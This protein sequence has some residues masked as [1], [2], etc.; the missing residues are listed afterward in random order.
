MKK[1]QSSEEFME[2]LRNTAV[3]SDEGYPSEALLAEMLKIVGVSD[4]TRPDYNLCYYRFTDESG[5]KAGIDAFSYSPDDSARVSEGDSDSPGQ[6]HLIYFISSTSGTPGPVTTESINAAVGEL[7]NL[8]ARC[9]L[10]SGLPNDIKVAGSD[11]LLDLADILREGHTDINSV[12]LEVFTDLEVDSSATY[13]SE[14]TLG[15]IPV[16]VAI[17]TPDRLLESWSNQQEGKSDNIVLTLSE[18]ST[19]PVLAVGSD[20]KPIYIT[21]LR[22]DQLAEFYSEYQLQ[23]VN[24]NIRAFLEFKGKTNK[25]IRDTINLRPEDFMSYNNGLTIVASGIE[26]DNWSSCTHENCDGS[27]HQDTGTLGWTIRAR[28]FH[29]VQI[30]N[31]GQTTAAIYHCWKDGGMKEQVEELRVFAKIVIV[32]KSDY[33]ERDQVVA[34]IA[35]FSNS[36]N[37]VDSATLESNNPHFKALAKAADSLS[38][39]SGLQNSGTYWYFDRAPGRYTAQSK[40]ENSVWGE[41]HPSVQVIDKYDL[42]EVVNCVTG[43]PNEAQKG[44]SGSFSA[45]RKLLKENNRVHPLSKDRTPRGLCVFGDNALHDSSEY[46]DYDEEWRG[47]IASVIVI[48]R[49][50]EILDPETTSWM[51]TISRRYV[52]AMAYRSFSA[53]WDHAWKLQSA[54][55]AFLHHWGVA[56][57]SFD[58]FEDWAKAALA[59]VNTAMRASLKAHPGKGENQR[60]Q[61]S[62]TW[63][64][65]QNDFKKSRR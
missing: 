4:P 30:V 55:E 39:P 49:L 41:M 42:A 3:F 27:E 28:A 14:R 16:K 36:Q 5:A 29:D 54:D 11:A 20:E 13:V 47:T 19:H 35:K 43:R 9:R 63:E 25:G 52:L 33:D 65:A 24:E 40:S 51:R 21:A 18:E 38:V 23:A 46:D 6:L 34:A 12:R 7:G 26:V 32:D 61:M 45:Y 8:Y 10:R 15:G 58:S 56:W 60:A 1:F 50:K 22:G 57:P 44:K 2:Y 17:W 64:R 62:A 53:L 59:H 31:G 48:R 37:K